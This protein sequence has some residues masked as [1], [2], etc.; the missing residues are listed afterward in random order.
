MIYPLKNTIQHYDWGSKTLMTE[1]FGVLNVEGLPQAELWMGAH[2]NGC[3]IAVTE[4]GEIRL[5]ELISSEPVT[6]LG[7]KVYDKFGELPF[8]LKILAVD[9]PL[10]I[11][12]HPKKETAIEGYERESAL[13]I[14]LSAS[15][16]N[17]KDRNHKPELI[18]AITEFKGMN[19]FRPV[20][21][22]IYLFD[23]I[24]I[25]VLYDDLIIFKQ[26]PNNLGL[27]CFFEAVFSLNEKDLATATEEL[28]STIECNSYIGMPKLAFDLV[29]ECAKNYPKDVGLFAPLLLNIIVLQPGEA[30]F[31]EAQTPHAYLKGC[32]VEIMANSD[33]VLRA[34]LTTKHIDVKELLANIKYK[35]LDATTI[36]TPFAMNGVQKRFFVPVDDFSLEYIHVS[37]SITLQPDNAE[38][39]LCLEDGLVVKSENF[40][41]T[42]GKGESIFIGASTDSYELSG[43]GSVI[44]AFCLL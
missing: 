25:S 2:P 22:I 16:R 7:Q 32:G 15:N 3:S 35:S 18:Y 20:D 5:D 11:Q 17:Y 1:L 26:Q 38:I 14:P 42:M 12:V 39:I 24:S 33:N 6:I 4:L 8:L 41:H 28:L 43:L 31:L 23:L 40:Q 27:S 9:K 44:R 19:G 36:K 21:E 29:L 37:D 13:G 30:M 10:S 34:G